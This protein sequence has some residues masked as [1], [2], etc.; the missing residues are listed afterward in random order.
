MVDPDVGAVEDEK[1]V[2]HYS[3]P[4]I[5][6][7]VSSVC[8]LILIENDVTILYYWVLLPQ[9]ANGDLWHSCTSLDTSLE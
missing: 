8:E 2:F 7:R 5:N 3:E 9:H 6:L 1:A 4:H